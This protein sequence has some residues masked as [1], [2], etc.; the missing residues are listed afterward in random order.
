MAFQIDA[1]DF[2]AFWSYTHAGQFYEMLKP[3]RG[4]TKEAAGVPLRMD[5]KRWKEFALHKQDDKFIVQAWQ[6][7]IVVYHAN[8]DVDVN[9]G[10]GSRSTSDL[11]ERYTPHGFLFRPDGITLGVA[12]DNL[13]SYQQKMAVKDRPEKTPYWYWFY[14][15]T[16][17]VTLKYNQTQN[18]HQI[19]KLHRAERPV[20]NRARSKKL[21]DKAK[22]FYEYMAT[23]GELIPE[24]KALRTVNG[25]HGARVH[26]VDCFTDESAWGDLAFHF[27]DFG[28]T[29]SWVS[30]PQPG[31]SRING[32]VPEYKPQSVR[33]AIT[34]A[35]YSAHR[36]Y[37]Y[38][39]ELLPF[40]EIHKDGRARVKQ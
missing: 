5:R 13:T 17:E 20:I 30:Q 23:M 3:I 22:P 12:I 38:R 29:Y 6:T 14:E 18:V 8:G 7:N 4:Q 36:D 39:Y 9:W 16:G 19:R 31:G 1:D 37:V 15:P 32:Y 24:E 34:D 2:H 10:Y 26:A 25:R 33:N 35:L 11:C 27:A 21:R 28:W 40:G